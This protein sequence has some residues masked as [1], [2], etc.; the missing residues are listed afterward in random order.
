MKKEKI[1]AANNLETANLTPVGRP[2]KK[3][4]SG[5]PN[6]RPKVTQE[7]IDLIKAC[8]SKSYAALEVIESLMYSARND[9]VRLNAAIA[10]LDRG[11][12]KPRESH[13]LVGKN[14]APLAITSNVQFYI[15][16]NGRD[17]KKENLIEVRK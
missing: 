12:G 11:Y 15:P 3:G 16:E 4:Q 8:K 1:P 5:N 13:E 7:E 9:Q 14:G 6:G 10:I 17:L 2:F